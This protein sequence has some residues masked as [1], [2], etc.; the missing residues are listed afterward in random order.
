MIDLAPTLDADKREWINDHSTPINSLDVIKI[1]LVG[2]GEDGLMI[3]CAA[4]QVVSA[5]HIFSWT[6]ELDA[7]HRRTA[8]TLAH[9][10]TRE[11]FEGNPTLKSRSTSG[12]HIS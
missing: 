1:V 10:S 8:H 2:K 7:L 6:T 12:G 4:I 9:T 3:S 5:T 11:G